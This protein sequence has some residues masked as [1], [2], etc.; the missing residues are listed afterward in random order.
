MNFKKSILFILLSFLIQIANSQE[1]KLTDNITFKVRKIKYKNTTRGGRGWVFSPKG[2]K[3]LIIDTDFYGKSGKKVKLPLF[4]MKFET[5]KEKYKV[6][7]FADVSSEYVKGFY[8]KIR[9]KKNRNLYI[10]VDDD[11]ESGILYF[12]N[13]KKMRISVEKDS[14]VG[15]Y[16]ILNK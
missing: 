2:Y 7:P 10:V 9:K 8:F 13:Q 5:K 1:I 11:F 3:F 14:K 6:R 16:E 4:E 12:K 15:T